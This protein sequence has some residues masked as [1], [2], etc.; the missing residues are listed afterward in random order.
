M[1]KI[2]SIIEMIEGLN[3]LELVELKKKME[4]KW[5]VTAAAPVMAMGVAAPVAA[6]GDGAAAAAPV[7][8]KTEFDVILKEAGP[9]RIQ[10]I[11]VVRELTSLGL[12][13][14]KDLVEGAPKPVREG[15]SKEEA[16][17]AKA[18][19]TEVGAVVEVK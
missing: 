5:G 11:K 13:E 17:A 4:E 3:V 6:A 16:E 14:A 9:N 15:V 18:K 1:S 10:V 12:K 19:L 2:D 7:E 8:E